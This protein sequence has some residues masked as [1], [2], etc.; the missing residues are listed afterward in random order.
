MDVYYA[1][2]EF[3]SRIAKAAWIDIVHPP[4]C[5]VKMIPRVALVV[6]DL[7]HSL[8]SYTRFA[9]ARRWG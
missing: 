2:R 4:V 9:D 8:L 3:V 5:L 1:R 7:S 6:L